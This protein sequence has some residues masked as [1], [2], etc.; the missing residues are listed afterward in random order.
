[1]SKK[2]A[3]SLFISLLFS[4]NYIICQNLDKDMMKAIACISLL[5][6]MED[7]AQDQRLIS[8]YILTCFINIDDATTQKLISNQFSSNLNLE[9]SEIEKLT[10]IGQL[11]TKYSQSEITEYSKQLN[12]AL[13]K[14]K[15][16]NMGQ[17]MQ[18]GKGGDTGSN[19]NSE[20]TGL[21]GFMIKGLI[22]LFNPGDSFLFLIGL[23][24]LSYFCLKSLR[25]L[26]NAGKKN[27]NKKKGKK[28]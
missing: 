11:Q 27:T 10:D 4:F 20:S 28:D 21:I 26:L 17:N 12:N 5:K 7:K 24:I 13:E 25:K 6:K 23:F 18:S 15:N 2:I 8:G 22:G 3:L 14:L 1:M 16:S 9:K 19:Q